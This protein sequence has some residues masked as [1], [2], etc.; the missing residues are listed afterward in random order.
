MVAAGVIQSFTLQPVFRLYVMR[1]DAEIIDIGRYTADF[2]YRDQQG[3]RIVEDVKSS[4][5]KTTAYR[6]R[7]RMVEAL[8]NIE[9]TEV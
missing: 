2:E 9:I 7:K 3:K 5:T 4:A 1:E 8:Y 6:L